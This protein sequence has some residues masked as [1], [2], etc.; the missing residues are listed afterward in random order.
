MIRYLFTLLVVSIMAVSS[1][2]LAQEDSE[3]E[4][5]SWKD[6]RVGIGIQV[7]YYWSDIYYFGEQIPLYFPIQ[8][9]DRFMIE[10]ALFFYKDKDKNP[11]YTY[12]YEVVKLEIGLFGVLERARTHFYGGIRLTRNHRKSVRTYE[13]PLHD[14]K[15]QYWE[16]LL[17]PT[18]GGEYFFS[19]IFSLGGELGVKYL[20]DS[21]TEDDD[22]WYTT[23]EEDQSTVTKVFMRFYFPGK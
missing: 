4:T 3:E 6:I 14:D 8:L 21:K 2:V 16:T 23:H 7:P 19:E 1:P 17:T 5:R 10:P 9:G 11:D 20:L 15:F 13:D 18:F 12:V 22:D